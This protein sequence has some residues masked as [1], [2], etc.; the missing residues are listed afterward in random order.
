MGSSGN[1]TTSAWAGGLSIV[2]YRPFC[3]TGQVHLLD[4]IFRNLKV[5]LHCSHPID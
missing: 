4:G 1:R 5:L 3:V 2:R